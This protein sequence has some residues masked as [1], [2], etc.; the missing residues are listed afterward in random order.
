MSV[1]T[2]ISCAAQSLST[3][4][5][6]LSGPAAFRGLIL[7]RVF[8]TSAGERQSTWSF[9]DVSSFCAGVTFFISN[10]E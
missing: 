2:S 8:F 4:P 1:R 9:G 7:N 3:R 5:G 6:M 10:R